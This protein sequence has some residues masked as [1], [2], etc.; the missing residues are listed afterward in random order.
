MRFYDP[1]VQRLFTKAFP[2]GKQPKNCAANAATQ[3]DSHKK[4]EQLSLLLSACR[5]T[6][7]DS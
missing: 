2:I 7:N 4:K 1:A 3:D 5:R 6:A